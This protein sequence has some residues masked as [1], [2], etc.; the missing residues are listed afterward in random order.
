MTKEMIDPNTQDKLVV[1]TRVK[2]SGPL[3]S[4]QFTVCCGVAVTCHEWHC[5]KC[6]TEIVR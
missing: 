3:N 2:L 5:P 4:T 6:D 1:A